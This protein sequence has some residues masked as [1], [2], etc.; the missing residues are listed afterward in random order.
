MWWINWL[1]P[2]WPGSQDINLSWELQYFFLLGKLINHNYVIINHHFRKLKLCQTI[3]MC[4]VKEQYQN[5]HIKGFIW[6]NCSPFFIAIFLFLINVSIYEYGMLFPCITKAFIFNET[7]H[8]LF[9]IIS[10]IQSRNSC[11]STYNYIFIVHILKTLIII[12]YTP[13]PWRQ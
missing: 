3:P 1:A 11:S 12:K 5:H 8:L 2:T 9:I 7:Q 10:T 4:P 6:L 13:N